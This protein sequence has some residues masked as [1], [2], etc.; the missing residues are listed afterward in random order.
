M[1]LYTEKKPNLICYYVEG[2]IQETTKTS[3]KGQISQSTAAP[4]HNLLKL[5]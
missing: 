5:G 4:W 1:Y 2:I 3:T